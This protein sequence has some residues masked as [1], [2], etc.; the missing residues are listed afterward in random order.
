MRYRVSITMAPRIIPLIV[1]VVP[2]QLAARMAILLVGWF[3]K[4]LVGQA[5]LEARETG[6]RMER[7]GDNTFQAAH[8]LLRWFG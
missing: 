2:V 5:I 4:R 8:S 6:T 1:P 7:S 3:H